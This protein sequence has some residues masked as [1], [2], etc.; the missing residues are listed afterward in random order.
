MFWKYLNYIW[1][2]INRTIYLES[3]LTVYV[4]PNIWQETS[5]K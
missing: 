1:L 3:N 5:L 4:Q 2:K